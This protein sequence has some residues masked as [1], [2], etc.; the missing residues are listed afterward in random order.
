MERPLV[1]RSKD[2]V[3]AQIF[4]TNRS[5]MDHCIGG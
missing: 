2:E 3:T 1:A 5:E 4:S